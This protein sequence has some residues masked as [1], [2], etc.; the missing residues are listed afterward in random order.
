MRLA[1]C[2]DLGRDSDLGRDGDFAKDG[3]LGR[4]GE[5]VAGGREVA[6]SANSSGGTGFQLMADISVS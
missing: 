1:S 6:K 3:A 4:D 5:L 2:I